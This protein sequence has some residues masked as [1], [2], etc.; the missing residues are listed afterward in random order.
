MSCS[1][2][3]GYALYSPCPCCTEDPYE[4]I[5]TYALIADIID[6]I[7]CNEIDHTDEVNDIVVSFARSNSN[8][9]AD[10]DGLT[11]LIFSELKFCK[12][13]SNLDSE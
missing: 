6:K 5:D 7:K 4:D 2:C 1:E 9:D 12:E 13:Y 3:R 8:D 10:E 11:D